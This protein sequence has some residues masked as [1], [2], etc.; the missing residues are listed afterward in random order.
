MNLKKPLKG[1]QN[2]IKTKSSFNFIP[3][4]IKIAPSFLRLIEYF[5]DFVINTVKYRVLGKRNF[6]KAVFFKLYSTKEGGPLNFPGVF[7]GKGI[8]KRQK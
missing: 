5:S 2:T 6:L 3:R 1:N 7:A 4:I 8:T